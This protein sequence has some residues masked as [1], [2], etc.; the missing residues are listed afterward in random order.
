MTKTTP[1]LVGL[2]IDGTIMTADEFISSAVREAIT[3][4]RLQGHHVVLSTGRPLVAVL[5]VL[6]DLGIDSGWAVCSNGSVTAHIDPRQP[7]GF[8]L[9]HVME[10]PAGPAVDALTRHL[11]DAVIGLE[12]VGVGYAISQDFGSARLHG[13]HTVRDVSQMRTMTTPRVVV[14]RASHAP[15]EFRALMADMGLCDSYYSIADEHW[16]DLAP[17]GITKAYGLER[18][19]RQLQVSPEHTVAVGDADNDIE[20][21]QWA[22]RGVAMGHAEASVIAAADEVTWPIID[23]G[24]APVLES[25]LTT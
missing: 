12:E 19:R 3:E 24:L 21:L 25:L 2:D 10:F 5:P 16:M 23:D 13:D 9:E 7:G 4:L 17:Q 11:P 18:L 15:Q 22:G 14:A 8:V 20:M 1:L 6:K